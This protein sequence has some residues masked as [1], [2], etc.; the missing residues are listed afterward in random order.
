MHPHQPVAPRPSRARA[1]RRARLRQRRAGRGQVQDAAA[2]AV[3]MHRAG[4]GDLAAVRPD[5]AGVAGLAAGARVEHRAVELDA[6]RAG[7][8]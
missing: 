6:L 1:D 3:G 5:A 4:H 2:V 8:R 7:A